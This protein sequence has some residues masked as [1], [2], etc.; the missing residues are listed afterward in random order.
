VAGWFPIELEPNSTRLMIERHPRP[1]KPLRHPGAARERSARVGI[2]PGPRA[3][4][5]TGVGPMA[6]IR[7]SEGTYGK[8][9]S[10]AKCMGPATALRALAAP[11]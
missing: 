3:L 8:S 6:R 10:A 7:C 5:R 1:S 4:L 11:G 2:R 9:T